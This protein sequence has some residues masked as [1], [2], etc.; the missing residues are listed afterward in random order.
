MQILFAIYGDS[1]H[2]TLTTDRFD[3]YPDS[4]FGVTYY[5]SDTELKNYYY[6]YHSLVF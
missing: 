3:L 2:I 1:E 6:I 4:M 5:L